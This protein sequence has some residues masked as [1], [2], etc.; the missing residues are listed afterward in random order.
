MIIDRQQLEMRE[1]AVLAAY[2]LKA[3]DSGGRVYPESEP[4]YRTAFQRDRD[5][6]VHSAAFRRLEYK[7]QVFMSEESDYNRTRLTHTLEVAQIGRTIARA[8]GANEDLVEAIC[9][10]HDLGHPPF[11]HAGERALDK[12][13]SAHGGFNHNLQ[14]YRVVTE[15]EQRY[16]GWPGLNLTCETLYGMA[17]HETN[18]DLSRTAG[19]DPNLR[20]GLEAQVANAVDELAYNAHDLD[21]GLN[22]GLLNAEA[23]QDMTLWR[24]LLERRPHLAGPLTEVGRHTLIRDLV[25]LLVDDMLE[26]TEIALQVARPQSSEDVKH[27]LHNLVSFSPPVRDQMAELKA[28]LYANLYGSWRIARM[29]RRAERFVTAMMEAFLSDPRQLP[30]STAG[31]IERDGLERAAADYVACMTDKGALLEYRRLFDPATSP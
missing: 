28:Y 1:S 10:A 27:S 26:S 15:L 20:G 5:R 19:L 18:Y 7:T 14:S 17:K 9:L 25:G 8:L 11:G 16:A 22:A 23:L 31:S 12:L 21:D 13:L 30:P 24:R 3:A 2:A 4:A 6:I 29:Q